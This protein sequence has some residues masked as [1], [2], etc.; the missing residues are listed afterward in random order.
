[1]VAAS[2][3]QF[4]AMTAMGQAAAFN[5]S[6]SFADA[7]SQTLLNLKQ[8]AMN[9]KPALSNIQVAFTTTAQTAETDFT[10]SLINIGEQVVVFG[11]ISVETCNASGTAFDWLSQRI[12][13]VSS[14]LSILALAMAAGT[15]AMLLKAAAATKAAIGIGVMKSSL[16]LGVAAPM[17]VAGA[18]LVASGIANAVGLFA[19][20]GFPNQ[21]EMFI[22]REAGPELVGSIGGR[23]AVANNDQIVESVSRGVFDAVRSAMGGGQALAVNVYLDGRQITGAVERTQRERG[24]SLVSGAYA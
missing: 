23:T 1:M 4:A 6:Q 8:L 16:T 21:G 22:A 5:I 19:S 17:I 7:F 24:L 9:I 18:A 12:G 3:T 10:S 20:G 2:S 11:D 15:G 13:F 14:S